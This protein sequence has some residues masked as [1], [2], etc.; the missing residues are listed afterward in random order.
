MAGPSDP[1]ILSPA[2]PSDPSTLRRHRPRAAVEP[3]GRGSGASA[4]QG[5]R[6]KATFPFPPGQRL[7]VVLSLSPCRV[8]P[9]HSLP[10]AQGAGIPDDPMPEVL[11]LSSLSV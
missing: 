5:G 8:A 4:T 6:C 7:W 3:Q 9:L 10:F 11:H 1:S 2:V